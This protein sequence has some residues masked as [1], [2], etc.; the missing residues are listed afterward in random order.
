M[1]KQKK[2]DGELPKERHCPQ[3][4]TVF[5]LTLANSPYCEKCNRMYGHRGE[6]KQVQG[7]KARNVTGRPENAGPNPFDPKN[8]PQF[9]KNHPDNPKNK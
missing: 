2:K 8:Y 3:C 6:L 5:N 7:M 1:A 4:N 9:S